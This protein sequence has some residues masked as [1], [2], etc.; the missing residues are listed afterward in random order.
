MQKIDVTLIDGVVDSGIGAFM[1]LMNADILDPA[2][3]ERLFAIMNG[4]LDGWSY[5]L[6]QRLAAKPTDA[7]WNRIFRFL[8]LYGT[9]IPPRLWFCELIAD[10]GGHARNLVDADP[11]KKPGKRILDELGIRYR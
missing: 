9:I 2:L 7:Q 3:E 8:N 6:R 1:M 10:M 4:S 11:W 5:H